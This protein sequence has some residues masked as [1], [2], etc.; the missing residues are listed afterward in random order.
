M[1]FFGKLMTHVVRYKE[2]MFVCWGRGMPT[3]KTTMKSL[4]K[5]TNAFA[6]KNLLEGEVM[7]NEL[8]LRRLINYYEI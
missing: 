4:Y 3:T 8:T 5:S 1:F 2:K 7:S 6:K